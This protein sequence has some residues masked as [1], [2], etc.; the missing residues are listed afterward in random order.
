M[1][2]GSNG[3]SS[4]AK[5]EGGCSPQRIASAIET[6]RGKSFNLT[7]IVAPPKESPLRLKQTEQKSSA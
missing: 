4:G 5:I 1:F 2:W 3:S 6:V 7:T